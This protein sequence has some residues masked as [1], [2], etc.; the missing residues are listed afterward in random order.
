MWL[1]IPGVLIDNVICLELIYAVL[2]TS[3]ST[4][5]SLNLPSEWELTAVDIS[6][7]LVSKPSQG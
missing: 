7:T 4:K 3:P 5:T 2:S 1:S 6:T